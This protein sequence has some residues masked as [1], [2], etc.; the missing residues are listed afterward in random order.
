M[1]NE[2][3][4]DQSRKDT[5]RFPFQICFCDSHSWTDLFEGKRKGIK[6]LKSGNT[7][8]K[9]ELK[10]HGAILETTSVCMGQVWWDWLYKNIPPILLLPKGLAEVWR[11]RPRSLFWM[12]THLPASV[13]TLTDREAEFCRVRG[14]YL[15]PWRASRLLVPCLLFWCCSTCNKIAGTCTL[16][17][18]TKQKWNF[19]DSSY[20]KLKKNF[21]EGSLTQREVT[22][23]IRDSS[24]VAL[25][26]TKHKFCCPCFS[27][28]MLKQNLQSWLLLSRFS[29]PGAG[30][31]QPRSQFWATIHFFLYDL[32]AKGVLNFFWVEKQSKDLLSKIYILYT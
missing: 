25:R 19:I 5:G 4:L 12:R 2:K 16:F 22:E 28:V 7:C 6:V 14:P 21:F 20:V 27:L 30:K 29:R 13:S 3:P 23:A 10:V 17:S 26:F 24:L 11:P 18:Y 31:Q 1:G 15:Y 32:N 8:T 9:K